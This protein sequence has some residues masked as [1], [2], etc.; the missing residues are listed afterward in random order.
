MWFKLST[1]V[2]EEYVVLKFRITFFSNESPFIIKRIFQI[3]Q[4][5][6]YRR[7]LQFFHNRRIW[8]WELSVS[9]WR[10]FSSVII[11]NS[12]FMDNFLPIMF[13]TIIWNSRIESIFLSL[14]SVCLYCISKINK[15]YFCI[16]TM[17]FRNSSL[18]IS[19]EFC[20]GV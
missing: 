4:T 5:L 16:E 2:W 17:H 7:H 18:S 19:S 15:N 13:D 9:L 20:A 12:K 3:L 8:L 10:K 6:N 14:S 1:F 11:R